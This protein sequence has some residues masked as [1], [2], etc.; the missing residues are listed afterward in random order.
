MF[1]RYAQRIAFHNC[2]MAIDILQILPAGIKARMDKE[3]APL[4]DPTAKFKNIRRRKFTL[5]S[6]TD[7]MCVPFLLYFKSLCEPFK[8]IPLV[9]SSNQQVSTNANNL[10]N[11]NINLLINC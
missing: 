9:E 11:Y 3:L 10:I 5:E 6:Y 7:I 4:V 2:A 8:S 1:G